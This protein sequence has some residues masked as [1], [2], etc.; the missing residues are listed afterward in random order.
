[1]AGPEKDTLRGIIEEIEGRD[2]GDIWRASWHPNALLTPETRRGSAN[3]A[4]LAAAHGMLRSKRLG[5]KKS[6]AELREWWVNYARV[7][8]RYLG[9][10]ET[11]HSRIY[12]SWTLLPAQ[13]AW[14]LCGAPEIRQ[15]LVST[16]A[17]LSLCAA[18][19]SLSVRPWVWPPYRDDRPTWGGYGIAACGGRS[20]NFNWVDDPNSGG[21]AKM[22][23]HLAEWD[24]DLILYAAVKGMPRLPIERDAWTSTVW[25]WC[26]NP[27][28][29]EEREVMERAIERPDRMSVH[30][31]V[32]LASSTAGV[33]IRYARWRNAVAS[34][35]E[36][37]SAASMHTAPLYAAAIR[38]DERELQCLAVDPGNRS[39]ISRGS[40]VGQFEDGRFT[41]VA[42]RLR[43]E[44]ES[45]SI[46]MNDLGALLYV[47]RSSPGGME[48]E[49]PR[50]VTPPPPDEE[51]EEQRADSVSYCL[52]GAEDIL[53]S[54]SLSLGRGET[55]SHVRDARRSV[56]SAI[57]SWSERE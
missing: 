1:M 42:S 44:G 21:K 22:F 28:T 37:A 48:I 2:G 13:I 45:E 11:P 10:Q 17:H 19:V 3:H 50:A 38:F 47:V 35:M 31:L 23:H 25:R 15:W 43:G 12:L 39:D 7:S 16:Y 49:Y 9:L 57:R 53:T 56:R 46:E 32:G 55:R 26:E 29:W 36:D 4:T 20:W 34:V 6:F 8:R 40:A 52:E 41:A 30:D 5:D 18:P 54:L 33:S 51:V 27:L 14:T 24:S